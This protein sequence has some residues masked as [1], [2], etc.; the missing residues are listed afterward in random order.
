MNPTDPPRHVGPFRA[1]NIEG[2]TV[3]F[4]EDGQ[5]F[6]VR[7]HGADCYYIPIFSTV[8][9]LREFAA[10]YGEAVGLVPSLTLKKISDGVE[11]LSDVAKASR[12]IRVMADPFKKPTGMIGWIEV[13]LPTEDALPLATGPS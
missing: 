8:D 6:L 9:K 12:P 4:E 13:F 10:D 1:T 5:P 3:L 7:V 2:F 11:F